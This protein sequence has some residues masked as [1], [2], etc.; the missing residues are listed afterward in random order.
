MDCNFSIVIPYHAQASTIDFIKRQ[1]NYYHFNSMPMTVI[2][3]LSGDEIIK[4]QLK[5]FMKKLNDSRFEIINTNE[6]N[7][8]NWENFLNKIY[9]ALKR[10]KTP[11]VAIN[12]ADDVFIPE[13]LEKGIKILEQNLDIAGVKGHTIFFDCNSGNLKFSKDLAILNNCKIERLKLAIKDR[14]SIFYIIRRTKHLLREY[15]NIITLSK[16]SKIV[17]HSPYHIEHFLA[18][19]VASLGKV[20]VFNSPWRLQSSHDNNHNSHTPAAF[21]RIK[22]GVLDKDDYEWFKSVTGNMDGLGY[23]YYKFLW[24]CHQI[25]GISVTFKQVAYN[26]IHKKC[27]LRDFIC[28]STYL[29]ISKLYVFLQKFLP[30]RCFDE[31]VKL[32]EGAKDFIKTEQ[33]KLLKKYYFSENDVKLIESKKIHLCKS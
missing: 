16:K 8:T 7:I 18:L 22:L 17:A 11:Y 4:G 30:E 2:V 12:G 9:K 1:L 24:V 26:F 32:Y 15:K 3:A 10:V 23:H 21:L 20:C 13:E 5:Q 27:S 31:R 14:D 28:I 25:R 29:I 19:S 6:E 33:Y